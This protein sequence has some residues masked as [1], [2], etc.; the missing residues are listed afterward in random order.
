MGG[1]ELGWD[2]VWAGDTGK[3]G[4]TGLTESPTRTG[5]WA[6]TV[7]LVGTHAQKFNGK[8]KS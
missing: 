2:G 6:G 5:G 1:V 3:A 8:Y 7:L 4:G